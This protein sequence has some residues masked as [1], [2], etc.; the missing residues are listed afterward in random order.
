M[1]IDNKATLRYSKKRNIN[2]PKIYVNSGKFWY[3][4]EN[5]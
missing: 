3:D 4:F 5:Q 2:E 1:N